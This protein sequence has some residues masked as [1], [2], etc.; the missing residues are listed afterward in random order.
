[1]LDGHRGDVNRCRGYGADEQDETQPEQ[2]ERNVCAFGA[3]RV[4]DHA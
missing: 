3:D 2:D 1:M 4:A